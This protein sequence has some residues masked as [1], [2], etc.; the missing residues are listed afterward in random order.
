MITGKLQ[1]V[2]PGMT[3]AQAQAAAGV[4]Q[5]SV[6]R[7]IAADIKRVGEIIGPKR[8][9]TLHRQALRQAARVLERAI[10]RQIRNHGLI[11]SGIMLQAAKI[12]TPNLKSQPGVLLVKVELSG[13]EAFYSKFLEFGTKSITPRHFMEKA[14]AIA[15]DE[16]VAVYIDG[17]QRRFEKELTKRR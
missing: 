1:Y 5:L 3:A 9:R 6:P 2:P 15:V 10:Q 13:S 7:A 11:K 4:T 14:F 8:G 12:V 17:I 16:A